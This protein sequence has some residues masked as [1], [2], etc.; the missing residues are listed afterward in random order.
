MATLHLDASPNGS[1]LLDFHAE[2]LAQR[3]LFIINIDLFP[4][5][6]NPGTPPIGL[7]FLYILVSM[8]LVGHSFAQTG[9]GDMCFAFIFT[10]EHCT[11]TLKIFKGLNVKSI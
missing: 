6:F 1:F 10:E 7:P 11:L 3:S 8:C 2:G 9:T 5:H 4:L